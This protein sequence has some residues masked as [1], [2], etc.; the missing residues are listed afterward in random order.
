M[1]QTIIIIE[2]SIKTMLMDYQSLTVVIL[3]STFG[4]MLVVVVKDMKLVPVLVLL[5]QTPLFHMLAV[6][7]IV[8]QLLDIRVIMTHTTSMTYYGMERNI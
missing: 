1:H 6:T 4:L 3:I 2:Q 5:L 7:I 8:N